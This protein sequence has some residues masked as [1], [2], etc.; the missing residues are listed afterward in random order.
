MIDHL[1]DLVF[2]FYGEFFRASCFGLDSEPRTPRRLPHFGNRPASL[3]RTNLQPPA[4]RQGE[5]TV[6]SPHA[7]ISEPEGAAHLGIDALVISSGRVDANR[8]RAERPANCV[9][10]VAAD[11]QQ[12]PPAQLG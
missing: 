7:A 11:I 5:A 8:L 6:E 9:H 3:G 12:T 2:P 1:E 10:G 4:P